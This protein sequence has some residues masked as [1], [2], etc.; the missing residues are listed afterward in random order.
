MPL[1]NSDDTDAS[2]RRPRPVYRG[3]HPLKVSDIHHV[4]DISPQAIADYENPQEAWPRSKN[5]LDDY[6]DLNDTN[7]DNRARRPVI[8]QGDRR[9]VPCSPHKH[10]HSPL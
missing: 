9:Q 3:E 1:R 8:G 2:Y 7:N 5:N 10:S 4:I 6:R